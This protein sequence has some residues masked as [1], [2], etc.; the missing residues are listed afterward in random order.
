M[1][2]RQEG[3]GLGGRQGEKQG[4]KG[5]ER[6]RTGWQRGREPYGIKKK[7]RR[8]DENIGDGEV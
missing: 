1:V 2:R 3:R 7:S 8:K 6:W 4:A 5:T